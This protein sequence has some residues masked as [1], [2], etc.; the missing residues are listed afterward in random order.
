M[1]EKYILMGAMM[2][3]LNIE[4]PGTL[5]GA[6]NYQGP[7]WLALGFRPFYLLAAAFAA[8]SVPVWLLN[9]LGLPGMVQ[10][11]LAW[12]MHEMVFGFI[13][14]VVIGF[15]YTAGR[16]WTGLWTPRGT[17]LAAVA[18]LWLAGRGAMLAASGPLTALIDIAFVP[19]AAWPLYRV[20]ARS[21]NTRNMVLVFMLGLLTVANVLFHAAQAGLL[22]IAPTRPIY[23]ALIVIVVI[24]AIVG[25]RVIPNFTGNA[26][27]GVK[28][29]QNEFLDRNCMVLTAL[30]GVAWAFGLPAIPAIL[31]SLGAAFVQ[32][33]RL[34]LWHP[35]STLRH[36]LLWILH[37]SYAW[38]PAG[39]VM[40]AA[41]QAGLVPVTV[42]VHML[43]V[44]AM[45]GLIIGM[46]TRTALG[47]TG[48]PLAAGRAEVAMYVLIQLG[49]VLRLGA[50]FAAGDWRTACLVAAGFCWSAAFLVYLA[51]YGPRL[52]AP[53]VDGR[54]G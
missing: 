22:S 44:G 9:Y 3:L 34:T 36:P 45:A 47:H 31:L 12:H 15:L 32:S 2:A 18:A 40:L 1:R 27:P 24:E 49:V 11:D 51:S 42:A 52:C 46:M 28:P 17:H 50:A 23:A 8:V 21:G 5:A 53:R 20:L 13:V 29:V 25:G 43:G 19:V 41:S 48:R 37:L 6:G 26:L 39:F 7:A 38:I 35:L 10:V 33:W 54:E 14:A 4:D 16:N 30:A